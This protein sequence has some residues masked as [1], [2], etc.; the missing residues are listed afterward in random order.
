ML[1][2]DEP[3][4]IENFNED[5]Y[6]D[7][8]PDLRGRVSSALQ[9]LI[10]HGLAEGR[11]M[12]HSKSIVET[13]AKKIEKIKKIINQ[14]L[15]Y[16]MVDSL[17]GPSLNFLTPEQTKRYGVVPT[18]NVSSHGYDPKVIELIDEYKDGLL[19][20]CGAGKRPIYYPNVVNYEIAA[21]DSTDVIGV[22]EELP[23][24]DNVFDVV[25]SCAVLE[26]VRDPFRAASEITRVLKPGGKLFCCVP[27]LQPFHAYP[28]H[29]YNM[30]HMGLANL[31][32]E[33]EI[34]RQSVPDYMSPI[35]T[36]TWFLLIWKQ[37]LSPKT[38]ESFLDM[39]VRDL[40]KEPHTY[41][42]M[43]FVKELSERTNF[44]IASG[45]LLEATKK[46]SLLGRIWGW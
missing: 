11:R 9:H 1:K 25:I 35:Y 41:M 15:A 17:G 18:D 40:I 10:D 14:K 23:F 22:A 36:L 7:A 33:L 37:G 28:N 26:H 34:K 27:F 46:K 44:D 39:K 3:A 32:K 24:A 45:T 12:H 30:T 13:K 16:S 19:L 8:N 31:F 38:A 29:Y 2:L 6:L 43:P 42:D 21:Y 4:T 5:S 20:D